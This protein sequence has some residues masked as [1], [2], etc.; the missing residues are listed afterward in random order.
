M[1][2]NKNKYSKVKDEF[3]EKKQAS[4]ERKVTRFEA[5]LYDRI[6]DEFLK[7]LQQSQGEVKIS[8]RNIALTNSLDKIFNETQD[9]YSD[10]IETF[11]SDLI[12]IGKFNKQ[13][14]EVVSPAATEAATK[15]NSSVNR[16]IGVNTEGGLI[17]DGF[18]DRFAKDTSVFS[19]IKETVFRSV[20]TGQSFSE[21][22]S[23]LQVLIQGNEELQG[24]FQKYFRNYAYDTY[25]QIDRTYQEFYSEELE[26]SAF[27]YEGGVIE[28]TRPFCEFCNGKVFLKE[29]FKKLKREDVAKFIKFKGPGNAASGIPTTGWNPLI[30]LGGHGCRHTKNYI[31]DFLA[32]Q[33]R[34][35]LKIVNGKLKK[36]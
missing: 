3:I 36:V 15:V 23:E 31:S 25:N 21:L 29:E 10:L 32:V 7:E 11:S 19:E 9:E 27:M 18:L 16:I 12:Q 8:S 22:K 28:T 33:L 5:I 2:K 4:L 24:G 20:T 6:F 35:D 1:A 13:Y 34:D 30:D 14:F 26:L 17:K